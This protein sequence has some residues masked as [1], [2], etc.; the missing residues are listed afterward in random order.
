MP[1]LAE[2]MRGYYWITIYGDYL[3]ELEYA[4]RHTKI[5][6]QTLG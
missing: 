5:K 1:L 4:L 6:F 3:R 2:Q